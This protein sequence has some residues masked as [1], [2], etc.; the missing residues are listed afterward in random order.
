MISL[1]SYYYKVLPVFIGIVLCAGCAGTKTLAPAT[2]AL[3]GKGT[4]RIAVYPIENLSGAKA[5]LVQLRRT[6]QD[7]VKGEGFDIIPDDVLNRF[8]ARNRIRHVGGIDEETAEALAIEERVDAVLITSLEYYSD[9]YSPMIA[10]TARLVSA[11]KNPEIIWMDS[12]GLTGKDSPGIFDIGLVRDARE[13]TDKALLQISRSLAAK[14]ISGTGK[15]AATAS[16]RKFPPKIFYRS[17][18]SPDK[19]FR[20]VVLPFYN[21]SGRKFAGEIM[22]LH[23]IQELLKLGNFRVVEPGVVRNQL[24][25]F[26]LIMEVGPSLT[27]AT[28]IYDLVRANL[29][30]TGNILNYQ[31]EQGEAGFPR[32]DFSATILARENRTMVLASDSYNGGDDRVHFFDFGRITTAHGVA[33]EMVRGIV[34][35]LSL[36]VVAGEKK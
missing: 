2:A 31:D 33:L 3:G 4:Y 22:A 19:Q 6:L 34:E 28:D 35:S 26:R 11:G 25:Q 5:P 1:I 8:M 36:P 27:N 18:L 24:L 23:F 9:S 14:L 15:H 32:V 10:L 30:L 17:D 13:L 21:R 29:L 20:V 12:V 16:R 7:K